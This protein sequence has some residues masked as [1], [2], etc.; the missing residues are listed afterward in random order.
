VVEPGIKGFWRCYSNIRHLLGRELKG[1]LGGADPL[2]TFEKSGFF[3][4]DGL[5]VGGWVGG[6]GPGERD[7]GSRLRAPT[8]RPRRGALR[9]RRQPLTTSCR[10]N[11][12]PSRASPHRARWSLQSLATSPAFLR[13]WGRS[14]TPSP[15]SAACPSRT[16]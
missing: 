12:P 15:S 7:G 3:S 9:G 11:R 2:A 10:H 5:E 8:G 1:A 16:G 14:S 6:G 4:P 13:R